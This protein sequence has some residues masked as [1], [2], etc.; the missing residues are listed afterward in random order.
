[1]LVRELFDVEELAGVRVHESLNHFL[2]A[3][4]SFIVSQEREGSAVPSMH[5][6]G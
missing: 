5:H 1:V 6:C 3:T 2:Q 4:H